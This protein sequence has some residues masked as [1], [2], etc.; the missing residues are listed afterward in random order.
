MNKILSRAY[1]V[2]LW[3]LLRIQQ[4]SGSSTIQSSAGRSTVVTLIVNF[5][6]GQTPVIVLNLDQTT[7]FSLHV[8]SDSFSELFQYSI[9]YKQLNSQSRHSITQNPISQHNNIFRGTRAVL[10]PKNVPYLKTRHFNTEPS[11]LLKPVKF[12]GFHY[13][14]RSSAYWI[15]FSSFPTYFHLKLLRHVEQIKL[16]YC[17][18]Q[19]L[20]NFAYILKGTDQIILNLHI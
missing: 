18:K 15:T 20:G 11:E 13:F 4:V 14:S 12:S 10:C 8:H 17:Q 6:S 3:V 2:V 7:A 1:F 5:F 16:V 19:R 9:F